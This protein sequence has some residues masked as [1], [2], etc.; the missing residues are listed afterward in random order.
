MDIADDKPIGPGTPRVTMAAS[1]VYAAD[2]LKDGKALTQ[3]DVATV[4]NEMVE[5]S[6]RKIRRYSWR[7]HDDYRERYGQVAPETLVEQTCDG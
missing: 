4:G 5:A 6:R 3:A 2:R 1:A 7:D